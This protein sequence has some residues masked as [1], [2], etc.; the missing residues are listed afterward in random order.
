MVGKSRLRQ[1]LQEQKLEY[2]LH[3][4]VQTQIGRRLVVGMGRA[5]SSAGRWFGRAN[6]PLEP[7][8]LFQGLQRSLK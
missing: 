1:D 4:K 6:K 3:I 8:T 7:N 5:R 2:D